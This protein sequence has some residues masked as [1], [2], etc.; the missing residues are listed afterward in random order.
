MRKKIVYATCNY[1]DAYRWIKAHIGK[2]GVKSM[3]HVHY[4]I[5]FKEG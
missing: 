4:V 3:H 5:E 1:W 2:F